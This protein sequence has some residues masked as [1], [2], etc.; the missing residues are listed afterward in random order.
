MPSPRLGTGGSTSRRGPLELPRLLLEQR[1]RGRRRVL[2]LVA[3]GGM[4]G[5]CLARYHFR[6]NRV[7]YFVIFSTIMLPPQITVISFFRSSSSTASSIP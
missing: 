3:I 7:I 2:I 5:Y 1:D 4:A 6:G